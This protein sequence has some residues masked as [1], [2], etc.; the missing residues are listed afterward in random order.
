MSLLYQIVDE[1]KELMASRGF[2]EEALGSPNTPGLFASQLKS[3]ISNCINQAH[4]FNEPE[5]FN[6][7]TTG[8]YNNNADIVVFNFQYAYNPVTLE[9]RLN[10]LEATLD[11]EEQ[12]YQLTTNADLPHANDIYKSFSAHDKLRRAKEIAAKTLPN[13]L[14]RKL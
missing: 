10:G 1:Q 12:I 5:E 8:F 14:R 3:R 6:I 11:R 13:G 7:I 2:T 4:R 9:L